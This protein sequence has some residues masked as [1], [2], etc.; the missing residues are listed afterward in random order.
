[1]TEDELKAFYARE[2][3]LTRQASEGPTEKDLAMQVA[4]ARVTLGL[5]ATRIPA[6]ARHLDL[7]SSS[8]ALME[9]FQRHF[10]S[11]SVGVEPGEAYLN[12]SRGRGHRVYHSLESLSEAG[13]PLFDVV[14]VMHVLEHLPNPVGSLV[15]LR[16]KYMTSRGLLLVEVPNLADHQSFELAHL[17]AF[18]AST[19]TDCLAR[20]GFRKVW[21]RTHGSFRSPVLRLYITLLARVTDTPS[22]TRPFPFPALRHRLLRRLGSAKRE[23]FTR[24]YP[25]WTWQ[26]PEKVIEGRQ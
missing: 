2:Y 6:A 1:M 3:R 22:P 14:S 24:H 10:G 9:A 4:R 19:L 18:T 20:A 5:I 12:Y 17:H 23:F 8:G 26:S 16:E 11:T 13:E 21:A 15:E 7:G 25:D